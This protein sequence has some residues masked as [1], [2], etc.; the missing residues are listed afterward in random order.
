MKAKFTVSLCDIMMILTSTTSQ[1]NLI[2]SQLTARQHSLM[3]E[4]TSTHPSWLQTMP[5]AA[6]I[7]TIAS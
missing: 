7:G 5:H 1:S 6:C 2:E 3:L 4:Q